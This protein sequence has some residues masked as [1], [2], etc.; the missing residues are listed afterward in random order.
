MINVHRKGLK[1]SKMK[2]IA[3]FDAQFSKPMADRNPQIL[4]ALYFRQNTEGGPIPRTNSVNLAN[5]G[6]RI[7]GFEGPPSADIRK[8][9]KRMQQMA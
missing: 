3:K 6:N 1:E 4:E 7:M 8:T 2:A 9:G 5:S